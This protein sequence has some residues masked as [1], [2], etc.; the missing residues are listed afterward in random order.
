MSTPE[1]I[2]RTESSIHIMIFHTST[3]GD[4]NDL[5]NPR[6]ELGRRPTGVVVL[7]MESL[8]RVA[9]S[10]RH[11]IALDMRWLQVG[12]L[13]WWIQIFDIE[14]AGVISSHP[15]ISRHVVLTPWYVPITASGFREQKSLVV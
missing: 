10:L 6:A 4:S 8:T 13:V 11:D 1:A 5:D 3:Q 2:L 7:G 15:E 9:Y 12:I 14:G